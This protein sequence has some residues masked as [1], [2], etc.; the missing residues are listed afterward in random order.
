MK[1]SGYFVTGTDTGVGKTAITV[2]LIHKLAEAGYRVAGMKPVASGCRH[3]ALGLRNEDAEAI[4]EAS[5]SP[6]AY[7]LVNP[8]AF[9]PAIAP[10]L[11][12]IEAGQNI[13]LEKIRNAFESIAKSADR[14][15]V[16]GVGGWRV[17]LGR[18]IT[19]EHM[20]KALDLPVIL[21]V[22]LRLGCLNHALLTA[23]AILDAGMTLA[24]W[25]ANQ[26]DPEMA[27]MSE[28]IVSL[29]QRINAPMLGHI[30][31]DYKLQPDDIAARLN[32]PED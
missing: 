21:V 6:P 16:E 4:M 26:L 22:G 2:A 3:T 7:E 20:A 1:V 19:T 27:R 8:Y 11:A 28:N 18:V 25:V 15:V 13:E 9:A 32:L 29:Q 24:G 10:H 31:C 30:P 12:A 5:S 17:P 14:V 23:G